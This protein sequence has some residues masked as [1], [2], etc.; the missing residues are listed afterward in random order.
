[1]ED[2]IFCKIVEG[3][4]PSE[5]VFENPKILAFLDINPINKGHV[6]VIPK[7]HSENIFDIAEE[8]LKEVMLAA[9]KI[10]N[11]VKKATKCTGINMMQ[12]NG[13]SASQVIMHFH[14]HIIPRFDNDNLSFHWETKKYAENEMEEFKEN[15]LIELKK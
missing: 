14:M 12:G 10:S 4:I 7:K 8:D 6:L 15:I 11:A 1:M 9:K 13:K 5:K 2:C 3:K